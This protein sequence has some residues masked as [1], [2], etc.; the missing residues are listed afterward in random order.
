[1]PDSVSARILVTNNSNPEIAIAGASL[2]ARLGFE[3]SALT[4]PLTIDESNLFEKNSFSTV[5]LLGKDSPL[6]AKLFDSHVFSIPTLS[7]SEGLVRIVHGAISNTVIVLITGSNNKGIRAASEVL[8]SKVPNLWSSDSNRLENIKNDIELFVTANSSIGWASFLASKVISIMQDNDLDTSLKNVTINFGGDL[9]DS[10]LYDCF[11]KYVSNSFSVSFDNV[12]LKHNGTEDKS[13]EIITEN[14]DGVTS[15]W[16]EKLSIPRCLGYS[17]DGF[18]VKWGS[19]TLSN[20]EVTCYP[21]MD[22]DKKTILNMIDALRFFHEN[23]IGT[24]SLRWDNV[25]KLSLNLICTSPHNYRFHSSSTVEINGISD[26]IS[27]KTS[28]YPSNPLDSDKSIYDIAA[29]Y[30]SS[31]ILRD[32][33]SDRISDENTSI[34]TVGENEDL[35]LSVESINIAAR[36]GLESI[37]L[38]FPI[39]C[40]DTE[41]D[42][43]SSR[44][45]ITIG[46]NNLLKTNLDTDANLN[47]SSYDDDYGSIVHIP[48]GFND[49]DV[50]HIEGHN[51]YTTIE[52]AKGF[53]KVLPILSSDKNSQI[54]L[55]DA[56]NDVELFLS[57]QNNIGQCVSSIITIKDYLSSLNLDKLTDI[58]IETFTEK[59]TPMLIDYLKK[60]LDGHI[61]NSK[62]NIFSSSW[63]DE[64]VADSK[65]FDL[66]WEGNDVINIIDDKIIPIIRSNSN[67]NISIMLRVSEPED[68]RIKLSSL[69]KKR[70]TSI[71]VADKSINI[72][73]ISAYKQSYHW[74][75]EIILPKLLS[76]PV[77]RININYSYFHAPESEKWADNPS[78]WLLTLYP[79]DEIISSALNIPTNSIIFNGSKSLDNMFIVEAYDDQDKLIFSESFDSIYVERNYLD[80][81]P[82]L[83]TVHPETGWIEV[84]LN[85]VS[86]FSERIVTDVEKLWDKYQQF[87]LPAVK[88]YVLNKTNNQPNPDKE[89]FFKELIF[90]AFLSEHDERLNL[91]EE[92]LSTLEQLHEDLYFIT[93][94]YFDQLGVETIGSSFRAPGGVVPHPIVKRTESDGVFKYTLKDHLFREPV[95]KITTSTSDNITDSK[96]LKLNSSVLK[97]KI[98]KIS[99]NSDDISKIWLDFQDVSNSDYN[100]IAK[101]FS[102]LAEIISERSSLYDFLG[103]GKVTELAANVN[104]DLFRIKLSPIIK[105]DSKSQIIKKYVPT[106]NT[107]LSYEDIEKILDTLSTYPQ[108]NI[109]N[110]GQSIMGRNIKAIEVT[111]PTSSTH[112]SH[113]K[114]IT[115]KP[116][117][118]I[119][120]RTDAHE[121]SSNNAVLSM[122]N[123][124]SLTSDYLKRINVILIPLQNPDGAARHYDYQKLHPYWMHHGAR[125]NEYGMPPGVDF[126]NY[127]NMRFPEGKS[128]M[129]VWEK[130]LPDVIEDAHGFPSHEW[131]QP[132][133]GYSSLWFPYLWIPPA[134]YRVLGPRSGEMTPLAESVL[135]RMVV[136]LGRISDLVDQNLVWMKRFNKY[137]SELSLVEH[138]IYKEMIWYDPQL[139]GKQVAASSEMRGYPATSK[140]K[141]GWGKVHE[142]FP[143]ITT[144][145]YTSEVADSTAQ[146]E[147]ME[148]CSQVHYEASW[149]VVQSMIDSPYTVKVIHEGTSQNSKLKLSRNRPIPP[150]KRISK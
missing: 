32:H 135:D 24:D 30:T 53:S 120:C 82:H 127:P 2:G 64:F 22:I 104:G 108:V 85:D 50:L 109:W 71:G 144:M 69:I 48:R 38:S 136:S 16:N 134:M 83:G 141:G 117:L 128:L 145:S 7:D 28:S 150:P 18:R 86:V 97:S 14:S 121:A 133:S 129:R 99:V 8:S 76:L 107:V 124:L 20:L 73:V 140:A 5:F 31:G 147:Y 116:T 92:H 35:L 49:R 111:S 113:S 90:E 12:F 118:L 45:I 41:L 79:V 70:L 80:A 139:F 34:I 3:T 95:V 68:V 143:N 72:N 29:T 89:P 10:E 21:W 27:T 138:P 23:N 119:A 15:K 44:S 88:D 93:L 58:K 101:Q 46:S 67:S 142:L 126:F 122:V 56:K 105:N 43:N 17:C 75:K 63:M 115:F 103:W 19:N 40:L 125:F 26:L 78:K 91:R 61:G 148:L 131:S 100:Y 81:Y 9:I 146:G 60:D 132:F 25:D 74:V 39:A 62:L 13:I 98:S 59:S 57:N 137:A 130:W 112:V 6:F 33:D 11:K 87:V 84:K 54:T 110:V 55:N 1:M 65:T 102:T 52:A 106:M 4:F 123:T 37:G 94:D 66:S 51:L 77:K 36:I 96:I 47:N 114:I 42:D 149:S